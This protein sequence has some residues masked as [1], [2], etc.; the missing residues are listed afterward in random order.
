MTRSK[1]CGVLLSIQTISFNTKNL[2][3]L[4][5]EKLKESVILLILLCL[6]QKSLVERTG[7]DEQLQRTK[8]RSEKDLEL[9]S[10]CG[11]SS[12]NWGP[13]GDIEKLERM[14]REVRFKG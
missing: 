14:T 4:Y 12:C 13:R 10:N 2:T 3:K 8:T 6:G 5:C 7:K 11:C 1:F 9:F